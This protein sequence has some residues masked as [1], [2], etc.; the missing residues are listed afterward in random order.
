MASCLEQQTVEGAAKTL[1]LLKGKVLS[2]ENEEEGTALMDFML[3]DYQINGKTA[4]AAYDEKSD[5][6]SQ[7]EQDLIHGWLS[8]YTSLFKITSVSSSDNTLT[9]EDV[10]NQN[11][12]I[13]LVDVAFSQSTQ[14]GLI[15][16]IRLISLKDFNMTSGNAFVFPEDTEKLLLNQYKTLVKQIKSSNIE[17]AQRFIAFFKLNRRYGIQVLYQ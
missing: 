10:L 9:L 17:A 11:Q 4:I 12:D 2:L 5:R 14:P 3:H 1:G 16:F 6:K 7:E 15:L 13:K 8:S